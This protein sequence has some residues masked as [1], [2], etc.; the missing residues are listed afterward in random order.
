MQAYRSSSCRSAT[1]RERMPPP[2]GVVSG[3][4]IAMRCS[5]IAAS[6]SSG[7]QL[8]VLLNDFSPARTSRQTILRLPPDV[9]ATA[10][11]KT[12]ADARQMSGPVPSP[13][14][15]GMM[16][17][18]G[19]IQ[20]PS[21]YSI[22]APTAP[23]R[24]PST[25]GGMAPSLQQK[26]PPL[27]ASLFPTNRACLPPE[28]EPGAQHD[29]VLEPAAAIEIAAVEIVLTLEPQ[30]DRRREWDPDAEAG[31]AAPVRAALALTTDVMPD[32]N[33]GRTTTQENAYILELV[34]RQRPRHRLQEQHPRNIVHS[35][36]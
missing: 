21:R 6:V 25:C 33:D 7:S 13:S 1:L 19:T 23:P 8:P 2:T 5:R 18:S 24:R 31:H 10:A 20:W 11:S 28:R 12:L 22:L 16:G 36:H 9:L 26:G 32:P 3:P 14:M 35:I 15:N 17:W 30:T 4:L 29:V 34:A 27:Q